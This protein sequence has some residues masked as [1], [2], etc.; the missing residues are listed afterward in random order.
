M[1]KLWIL[2]AYLSLEFL[3]GTASDLQPQ[4]FKTPYTSCPN[5][6]ISFW[7]HTP[8]RPQG[9]LVDTLHLAGLP[10]TSKSL[11]VLIHSMGGSRYSTPNSVLIPELLQLPDVNILVVDYEKLSPEPCYTE[12]SYN[13][14]IVAGCLA[15]LLA[16]LLSLGLLEANQLHLIG[17]GLGAHAAAFTS[18]ILERTHSKVSHITAL[19]P[20]KALFLTPDVKQR[21]D[22]S[23][24][25]FVD[26]IH[27]DV[28]VLGL[29]Q[30][31][32]HVDFYP[33]KG[34]VQ[35][36]CGDPK[37]IKSNY[38]YHHRSVEYYA[39]SIFS[40]TKFWAFRCKDLYGFIVGECQPNDDLVELGYNTPRTARGNYFLGTNDYPPY[41]RGEQFFNLD[42]N[43]ENQ[44][45]LPKEMIEMLG[46][47]KDGARG[48]TTFH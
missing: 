35:P 11:K 6:N 41:A 24:A 48:L 32:G 40:P 43:L 22:P 37:D 5:E 14:H 30:P 33:N 44:T 31:V 12:S 28:M 16:T 13:I 36:N 42:R 10:L 1:F 17:L 18:N 23:D 9:I 26:V 25:E 46:K 45:F 34:V 21:I 29:M 20:S 38:C 39:E 19:N 8:L 7:L 47:M 27:T 3:I 4:C 2:F 15:Q